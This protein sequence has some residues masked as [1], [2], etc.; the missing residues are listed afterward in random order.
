MKALLM[1]AFP[2]PRSALYLPA[3]NA[4]AI[5]KARGLPADMILLDL[6]DAVKPE[7]KEAARAA[8]VEAVAIGFGGR[9]VAIRANGTGSVWHEADIAAIA[10][11]AADFI[12]LP[13]VENAEEATN[14]SVAAGKPLLAMIESPRAIF[15]AAQIAA[16]TGVAGL[17]GGMNDL[18]NEL[19]LPPGDAREGLVFALQSIVMA[20]RAARVWA[21]DGVFNK[22]EDTEG[23]AG[24]CREGRRFGYDG[25]T[26][27]HPNQIET[28][29][30][31]FSPSDA[32]LDQARALVSAASG[33]AE[34]FGDRMIETMHVEAAKRLLARVRL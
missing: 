28:A 24:E 13:K 6:E 9:P 8:A 16:A 17:I 30:T 26:L 18:A 21:L 22:L 31:V 15:S 14:C 32:E 34:R 19:R 4:R 12:I 7:L 27:I 3:S 10:G 33:G 20:A 25:K 23:L 1:N 11:S 2:A 5:E 29:N